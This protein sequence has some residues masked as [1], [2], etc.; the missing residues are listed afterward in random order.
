MPIITLTTDFGNKDF[1]VPALKGYILSH[2]PS[3]HLIDITHEV[4]PFNPIEASF[5]LRNSYMDFPPGTIHLISIESNQ[6]FNDD[7]IL[8]EFQG[9]YFIA[10]NNGIISLITE[11]KADKIIRLTKAENKTILFP[12]K[13]VMAPAACLLANNTDPLKLGELMEKMDTISSLNPIL[14]QDMIRG[15]VIYIDN[16]G[17]VISNINRSHI[18]RYDKSKKAIVQFSGKLTVDK[19]YEYYNDVPEGEVLCLFGVTGLLE[20]AVNKGNASTLFGLNVSSRVLIEF[21]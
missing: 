11:G 12:A 17:N 19:F 13:E 14:E 3:V 6:H 8:V 15:T 16:Y 20:I 2:V 21:I 1:F 4:N 18:D 10:H 5:V 7:Y 9:Q